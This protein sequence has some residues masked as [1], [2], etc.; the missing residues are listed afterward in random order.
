M[1]RGK[2]HP[3]SRDLS[4]HCQ[5]LLSSIYFKL[6]RLRPYIICAMDFKADLNEEF[7]LQLSVYGRFAIH[8]KYYYCLKYQLILI[9]NLRVIS[10]YRNG[11]FTGVQWQDTIANRKWNR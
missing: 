1:W 8:G 2:I 6:R 7:E 11:N 4:K 5:N 10:Y 3:S 9:T